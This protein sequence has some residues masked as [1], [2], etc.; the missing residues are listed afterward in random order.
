M[1]TMQSINTDSRWRWIGGWCACY[2]CYPPDGALAKTI[3]CAHRF[4]DPLLPHHIILLQLVQSIY[5][6]YESSSNGHTWSRRRFHCA[7]NAEWAI[8]CQAIEAAC[9]LVEG[10]AGFPY[11]M[12]FKC[13]SERH[14]FL[15][16][17]IYGGQECVTQLV[18]AKF[19]HCSGSLFCALIRFV[20]S[21]LTT[22]SAA[23]TVYV[24]R[25]DM[26]ALSSFTT[27]YLR[28]LRLELSSLNSYETIIQRK[29]V[30]CQYRNFSTVILCS[31]L[32]T[33]PHIYRFCKR[34]EQKYVDS[35]ESYHSLLFL[36]SKG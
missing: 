4:R 20:T 17:S 18:L 8:I 23:R 36:L 34:L 1:V 12:S 13:R 19:Y 26:V 30:P 10:M 21:L 24:F 3:N 14:D 5:Y 28:V 7:T 6:V 35:I 16:L 32:I 27:R 31:T 11:Y 2:G 25:Q 29:R 15:W 22:T 9:T 33:P